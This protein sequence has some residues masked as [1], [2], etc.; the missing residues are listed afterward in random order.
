MRVCAVIL[1]KKD[2]S[3]SFG[4]DKGLVGSEI[5]KTADFRFSTC[6]WKRASVARWSLCDE[7][8]CSCSVVEVI[9]FERYWCS[10]PPLPD[11]A[12]LP[13][14]V[15]FFPFCCDSCRDPLLGDHILGTKRAQ[16]VWTGLSETTSCSGCEFTI[17]GRIGFKKS[18]DMALF[19]LSVPEHIFSLGVALS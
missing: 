16:L 9:W 1:I 12:P 3:Q 5:P 15:V 13:L 19:D 17:C 14:S 8:D 7:A 2:T 18:H 11:S 4:L 10:A 6:E